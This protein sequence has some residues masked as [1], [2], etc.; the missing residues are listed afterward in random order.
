[1]EQVIC[2]SATFLIYF[3][4]S[5]LNSDINTRSQFHQHFTRGFFVQKFCSKLFCAGSIGWTFFWRNWRKLANKKM[6]VKFI[7]EDFY[8]SDVNELKNCKRNSA[9][10]LFSCGVNFGIGGVVGSRNS[11]FFFN[12]KKSF[13]IVVDFTNISHT[14]FAPIFFRQKSRNLNFKYKK[15]AHKT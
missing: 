1:M 13:T 6:L 14:A 12:L 15:A 7:R 5:Y 11:F 10:L 2:K 8:K 9:F 4:L 3:L